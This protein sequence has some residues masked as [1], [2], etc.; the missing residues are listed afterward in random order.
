MSLH[1]QGSLSLLSSEWTPSL[2]AVLNSSLTDIKKRP[3]GILGVTAVSASAFRA[4]NF[5]RDG[6][7][8]AHSVDLYPIPWHLAKPLNTEATLELHHQFDNASDQVLSELTRSQPGRSEPVR[9]SAA[10]EAQFSMYATPIS[11]VVAY[12]LKLPFERSWRWK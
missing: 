2:E 10:A 7:E 9:T 12:S 3:S 8:G 6:E 1:A 5:R 11:P 4:E